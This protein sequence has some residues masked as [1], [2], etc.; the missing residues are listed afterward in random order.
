MVTLTIPWHLSDLAGEQV[1]R[2]ARRTVTLTGDSW[3][4]VVNEIRERYPQLAAR[5]LTQ[6]NTL[7]AGFVLA[8]NDKVVR[9]NHAASVLRSGDELCIIAALA[10]G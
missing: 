5:V 10:G 9:S 6:S 4:G 7:A 1:N 8:V 3:E 2:S